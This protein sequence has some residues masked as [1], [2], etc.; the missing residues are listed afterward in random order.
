MENQNKLKIRQKVNEFMGDA[1]V[2]AT[3][4]T[5]NHSANFYG[6]TEI[7][8]LD[9]ESVIGCIETAIECW[10]WDDSEDKVQAAIDTILEDLQFDKTE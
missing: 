3:P 4:G 9:K 8:E 5:D 1:V 6:D 10:N 7:C 2:Y